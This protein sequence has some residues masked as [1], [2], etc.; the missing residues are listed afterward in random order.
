MTRADRRRR[1]R[2]ARRWIGGALLPHLAPRTLEL[3]SRSWKV[4]RLAREHY[5]RAQGEAGMLAVLWHGRML[6][7]LV[8]HRDQGFNVLVSPS[9]DGSLVTA[10]LDRFGYST[11]RGSSN[12]NPARA[13]REMLDSLGKGGR[14][15]ITP[16]GPRGP[17]H[18]VNLGP[19]WIARETGFPILPCGCASDRAWRLK[20]W[21]R[22]MIPK[23]G[24]RVA[25][26]Y[27][28][29]LYVEHG[30][31]DAELERATEEMRARLLAAEE[32]GFGHLGQSPDW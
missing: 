21:D 19:A 4:E 9:D 20:S 17:R 15:V 22:F 28:E 31:S 24:A 2:K 8:I 14:V 32:R 27:G 30:A 26:V 25:V 6:I 29:P 7:P 12:K 10:L 18:G 11:I 23:M 16:D 13:I 5:E 3:L 1:M